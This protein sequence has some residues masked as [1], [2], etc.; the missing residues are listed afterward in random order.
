MKQLFLDYV[1]SGKEAVDGWNRFWFT[2]AAPT[3]LA[4][5][6]I[7]VGG[8]ALYTHCV[9][10]LRLTELLGSDGF[11][12][13]ASLDFFQGDM[14]APSMWWYVPEAWMRTVHTVCA[15]VMLM[16]V[17]GIES[18]VTGILTFLMSVTARPDCRCG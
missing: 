1:R 4:V 18:R 3:K 8:M 16:F 6:R 14:L 15:V 5:L 7:L 2:P 17:L 9:W 12:S 10:G 13:A 11:N